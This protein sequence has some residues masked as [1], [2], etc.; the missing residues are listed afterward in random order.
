MPLKDSRKYMKILLTND[1]GVHAKGLWALYKRL[2]KDN[3]VT[4]VAPDR[5]RSAIGHGI[6]IYQP[7]RKKLITVNGGFKAYA[8]NGTPADCIKF[9][10]LEILGEKP[11][12]VISGINPGANIGVNINYS[13]TVAAAR[14]AALYGINALAVSIHGFDPKNYDAAACY[15]EKI[16]KIVYAKGLFKGTF[17]NINLPD[18]PLEKMRGVHISKQGLDHHDQYFE[19]RVDPKNRA[20][21]WQNV[22]IKP[23]FDDTDVDGAAL[24][25]NFI[26]ITPIKCDMT[27][28]QMINNLKK[29]QI[30][31]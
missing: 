14:E 15:I 6:T 17:L 3:F 29:W 25:N 13:G 11:D 31:I 10:I 27:D 7:L 20:Y 22:D 4:V 2:A 8:T 1:D 23:V 9:G 12:M 30:D 28:Y 26:S 21:Y 5:E 16:S 24:N 18:I 19:K